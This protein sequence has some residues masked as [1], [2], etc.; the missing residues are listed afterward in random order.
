MQEIE[1]TFGRAAVIWWAWIWRAMLLTIL[2]S[3]SIG[4]LLGILERALL[5]PQWHSG[6]PGMMLLIGRLCGAL[7]GSLI[8]IKVLQKILR[9]PFNGFRIALVKHQEYYTEPF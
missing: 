4:V 3:V 9:R 6:D 1:V 7:L 2:A 5:P 8:S